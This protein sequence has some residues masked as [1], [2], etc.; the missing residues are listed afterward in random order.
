[1]NLVTTVTADFESSLIVNY[2]REGG[3]ATISHSPGR[4][5]WQVLDGQCVCCGIE[6]VDYSAH[7]M[8][9]R[10]KWWELVGTRS[11]N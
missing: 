3:T 4:K 6:T 7:V 8:R 2:L 5:P 11:V 1:V 10:S 9:C